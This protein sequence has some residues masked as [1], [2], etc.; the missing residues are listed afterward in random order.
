MKKV[1]PMME[2]LYSGYSI[3]FMFD[4]TISHSVYVK[5]ALCAHKMNKGSGRQ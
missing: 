2:A 5:D 4:N 1:L 3:L